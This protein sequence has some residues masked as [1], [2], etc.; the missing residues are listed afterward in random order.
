MELK[1]NLLKAIGDRYEQLSDLS[2]FKHITPELDG[3]E[4]KTLEGLGII[5]NGQLSEP[6][7]HLFNTIAGAKRSGR[8]VLTTPSGVVE[9]AAYTLD[10]GVVLVENRGQGAELAL[11]ENQLDSIRYH[12]SEHL[13]MSSLQNSELNI[14][15]TDKEMGYLLEVMDWIRKE[16]L[17][18]YLGGY[19]PK[20]LTA[21]NLADYRKAPLKDGLAALYHFNFSTEVM[22]DEPDTILKALGTAGLLEKKEQEWAI[23]VDIMQFAMNFNIIENT[24]LLEAYQTTADE[25]I[26]ASGTVILTA[27]LKDIMALTIDGDNVL[28]ETLNGA[29]TIKRAIEYLSCQPLEA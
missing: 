11:M 28:L 9:K 18:N 20:V 24:M 26:M 16:R 6:V 21:Q 13:G 15:L 19:E 10:S 22:K 5:R 14:V 29:T 23:N 25:K 1:Y 12:L 17:M 2:L 8:L 4:E 3:S 7:N 27:G